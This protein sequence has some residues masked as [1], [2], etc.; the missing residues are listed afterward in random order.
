MSPSFNIAKKTR[1][2][3]LAELTRDK[4]WPSLFAPK[5]DYQ[6]ITIGLA[7]PDGPHPHAGVTIQASL[8]SPPYSDG[9]L[10]CAIWLIDDAEIHREL[11]RAHPYFADIIREDG[12]RKR[13]IAELSWSIVSTWVWVQT[14]YMGERITGDLGESADWHAAAHVVGR[15]NH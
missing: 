7:R 10:S 5:S 2:L 15:T 4:L 12:I 8:R 14:D 1:T 3:P 6:T 13:P 11:F 9:T